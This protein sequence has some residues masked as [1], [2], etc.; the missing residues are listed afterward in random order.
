MFSVTSDVSN[1]YRWDKYIPAV[2]AYF[3]NKETKVKY[4]EEEYK[5]TR[6]EL[7]AYATAWSIKDRKEAYMQ[8]FLARKRFYDITHNKTP[9]KE[10]A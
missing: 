9:E 6:K 7:E 10:L 4:L 3:D 1:L 2:T 8:L 5:F